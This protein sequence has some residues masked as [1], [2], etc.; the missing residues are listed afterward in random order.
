MTLGT[1]ALVQNEPFELLITL[2]WPDAKLS[3]N[4]RGHW[5]QK[6]KANKRAMDEVRFLLPQGTRIPQGN[7]VVELKFFQP[8]LLR[9]DI[10]NLL[11][12]L[13]PHLDA[14]FKIGRAND[15]Q[16]SKVISEKL[17]PDG[18]ARVELR[19]TCR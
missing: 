11:A 1:K 10:D 9:R 4:A 14:I 15:H 3:P 7:M 8:N 5:T 17:P 13:K 16:I 2:R 19:M 6:Y 12:C 18:E